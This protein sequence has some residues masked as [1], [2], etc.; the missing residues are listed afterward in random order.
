M[1]KRTLSLLMA[2]SMTAG[3]LAG[4]GS[5]KPAETTAAPT[6]AA[7]TTAAETKAEETTTAEE[8]K[9]EVTPVTLNIAYMP[10]YGSLWSIENAI[11]Q[12]YLEEE[13]ITANLVE[14]QDG[15]TIIAAMESGSIDL[16]YIGQGAHK[17]CINGQATIFAL[18]HISNGDALIG[19]PGIKT[20]EDLKGKT[21]AYSSGSSSE[22]ILLNSLTKA[23]MTMDD[24]TA[25]DMDASAIVTAMLSG[26]VDAAA[27][28]S[29]NSLKIL[30][31]M[32]EA[33]KLTDNMTFSDQTVSLASW[34]CMPK[35]AEENRDVLVRFTRALFKAMDYAANDHQEETAALVAAQVAQDKDSV[36][37]QRGDAQWMT[38]KE[39]AK[40]AADGTVEGYYELQKQ[41][42]IKSGAFDELG[43]TRKQFM[44]IYVQILDQVN[45]EKKNSMTGQMSLFDIVGEEQ[46]SEFDIPLPN[47]GEYEK[48][49][50]LAF[51]KEVLGIYL[52]GHPME[53][54]EEQWRKGI[55]KTTQDFQFDEELGFSRVRDGATEIIGGI[56]AGKT[57]KYTKNNKTMCFLTIED[58]MGSVEVVVFPR[59]YER[60][61]QYLEEENV[62]FVKG[63]V[64]EEDEASSKLICEKVIPFGQKKQELWIQ[65]PDK[66]T[67]LQGEKML[68]DM[69]ASSDGNDEVI[70]YCKAERAVKRLP[71][72]R[73]VN[74]EPGLL[75]RLMNYFGES[76]VKVVEKPLKS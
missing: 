75:S 60:Y 15:P 33:T 66:E 49:T 51:E 36:Y 76:C 42:F 41:N 53:E 21:V 54:Y 14:F 65:Y 43:G 64:S 34:I 50:K 25:M 18:S 57:I 2:A 44:V 45:R 20:V 40:G 30:E 11:D 68:Y 39:V 29:P 10:N 3:L 13:G 9:E 4:C 72:N 74:I 37:E 70:V 6:T 7:A 12:G 19:G 27:T 59:D 28:W 31:E 61:H 46:K 62:V 69:L 23:G 56:I 1:K 58:I 55:S 48:S 47:V 8:T 73:N 26:G 17:L 67:F 35:Y 24:I 16:G 52:S 22:D 71:S 32:P 5:S 38:G 63:R